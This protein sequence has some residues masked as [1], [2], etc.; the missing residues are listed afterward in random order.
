MLQVDLDN[1]KVKKKNFFVEKTLKKGWGDHDD[2]QDGWD[3]NKIT[4]S[5]CSANI[6]WKQ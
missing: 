4:S 2:G 5:Y 3:D 1:K 6:D